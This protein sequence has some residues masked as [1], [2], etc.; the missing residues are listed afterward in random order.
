MI[1]LY[2]QS[3]PSTTPLPS[4]LSYIITSIIFWIVA[5]LTESP[6]TMMAT[7]LASP[8]TSFTFVSGDTFL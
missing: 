3:I 2:K 7:L 1:H 8:I 5:L 6:G 4:P